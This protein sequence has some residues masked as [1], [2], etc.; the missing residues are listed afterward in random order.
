MCVCVCVPFLVSYLYT[1]SHTHTH[2]HTHTLS[3][4]CLKFSAQ[5]QSHLFINLFSSIILWAFR[6]CPAL[7]PTSP[8]FFP[9][10]INFLATTLFIS[11]H[12]LREEDYKCKFYRFDKGDNF[13]HSATL[14]NAYVPVS[15]I[16]CSIDSFNFPF[17]PPIEGCRSIHYFFGFQRKDRIKSEWYL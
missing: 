5:I 2:P 1:H 7:T 11:H 6:Y 4:F 3:L 9:L 13:A 12:F 16:L 15:L 10:T 17:P 14:S 8:T